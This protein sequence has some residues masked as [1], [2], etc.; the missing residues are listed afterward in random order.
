MGTGT[1]RLI[2]PYQLPPPVTI[3]RRALHRGRGESQKALLIRKHSLLRQAGIVRKDRQDGMLSLQD[4]PHHVCR[5]RVAGMEEQLI[6]EVLDPQTFTGFGDIAFPS[7]IV[8]WNDH[9]QEV[10]K[11][12]LLREK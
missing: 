12:I 9:E 4:V 5:F 6:V 11:D 2:D 10:P 7:G 1:R 8:R 3:E